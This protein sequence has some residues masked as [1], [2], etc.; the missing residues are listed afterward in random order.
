M[1]GIWKLLKTPGITNAHVRLLNWI[2]LATIIVEF[3][4]FLLVGDVRSALSRVGRTAGLYFLILLL[5]PT[6]FRWFDP[7]VPVER[8][9]AWLVGV[10]AYGGLAF[11]VAVGSLLALLD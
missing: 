8:K 3:L 2:V 7:G 1:S 4:L 10:A 11:A 5:A 6:V 9:G